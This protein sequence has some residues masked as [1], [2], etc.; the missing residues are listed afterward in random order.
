VHSKWSLANEFAS[1]NSTPI[2][3]ESEACAQPYAVSCLPAQ[4]AFVL[5]FINGLPGNITS[6]ED[7]LGDE[8]LA[9]ANISCATAINGD[10][11]LDPTAQISYDVDQCSAA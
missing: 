5:S 10:Y 6:I 9:A 7:L 1:R 3:L 4:S 8:D 11:P 2:N